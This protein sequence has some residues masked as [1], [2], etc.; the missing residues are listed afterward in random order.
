[1]ERETWIK[2]VRVDTVLFRYTGEGRCPWLAWVPASAG[3]TE[4]MTALFLSDPSLWVKIRVEPGHDGE[5]S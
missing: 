1:M 2:A 4:T 3:M 5:A